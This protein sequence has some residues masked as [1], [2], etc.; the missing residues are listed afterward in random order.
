[1]RPLLLS[2]SIVAAAVVL[3]G[4]PYKKRE[5][6]PGP[7]SVGFEHPTGTPEPINWF[8]GTLDEA[9]SPRPC[10]YR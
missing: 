6:L 2:V 10:R 7:Q 4:C 3:G 1:M 5:P 9:F 8:Q